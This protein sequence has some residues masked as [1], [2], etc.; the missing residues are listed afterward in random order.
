MT[1]FYKC[2]KKKKKTGNNSNLDLANMNAYIKFGEF[3]SICSQDIEGNF[4]GGYIKVHNSGTNVG[5]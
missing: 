2:A 1:L 5:K 3:L 4:F